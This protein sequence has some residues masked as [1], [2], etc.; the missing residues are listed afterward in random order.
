MP[1]G[2]AP[3]PIAVAPLV[4]GKILGTSAVA[5]TPLVFVYPTLVIILFSGEGGAP[6]LVMV[7][8]PCP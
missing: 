3:E 8:V 2:D 5:Q 1:R 7:P 4:T 6:V